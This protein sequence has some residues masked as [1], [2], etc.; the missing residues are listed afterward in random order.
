MDT[1]ASTPSAWLSRARLEVSDPGLGQRLMATG[2][3]LLVFGRIVTFS[4]PL[5]WWDASWMLGAALFL[6]GLYK[7][8][9]SRSVGASVEQDVML[10]RGWLFTMRIM[11]RN[12]ARL[13]IE[14][15]P[16][17][18][19]ILLC[20]G[21]T[22]WL[23]GLDARIAW[24]FESAVARYRGD[25][26]F[27]LAGIPR[28]GRIT[29]LLSCL[30]LLPGFV[31]PRLTLSGELLR[32]WWGP[33]RAQVPFSRVTR[34]AATGRGVQLHLVDARQFELSSYAGLRA[35]DDF[36][37]FE[38]NE[39]VAERILEARRRAAARSLAGYRKSV[40]ALRADS[41]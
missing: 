28:M 10:L 36:T 12:V 19:R 11:P 32:V 39:L 40:R 21:R 22:L 17:R 29:R 37:V 38:F 34:V 15:H 2:A 5:T 6:L 8:R 18:L 41:G 20:D 4:Q 27:M 35:Q 9:I 33:F 7:R 1:M 23:D 24:R 3:V 14:H 31:R 26:V 13:S 30:P 16:C 25:E